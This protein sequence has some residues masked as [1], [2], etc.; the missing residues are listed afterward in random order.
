M[1]SRPTLFKNLALTEKLK[2]WLS[3]LTFHTT[4]NGTRDTITAAWGKLPVKTNS[5]K[6]LK[7]WDK[8][9]TDKNKKVL[10]FF[11]TW[12]STQRENREITLYSKYQIKMT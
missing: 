8:E 5:E 10:K 2:S 11:Q 6:M 3:C 9:I 12:K 7:L 1:Q 4:D